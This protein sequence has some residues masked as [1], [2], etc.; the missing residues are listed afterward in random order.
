MINNYTQH[1]INKDDTVTTALIK[2]NELASDAILFLVDDDLKLYGSLTDGDLRRG[3][4]EGKTLQARLQAFTQENPKKILYDNY[5]IDEIIKY[6]NN[7]F[8]ILPIV[9]NND[10]IIDVINFNK[11]ISYLPLTAFI[12]AGGKGHR[13]RPLT[14]N[15]PKPMLKVGE[16]PILEHNIDSLIKYGIKNINISIKYLGHQIE[17]YFGNGSAKGINISYTNEDL[18]LGTIGSITNC[19]SFI[20]D[21]DIL[22]INSDLLTTINYEKM[23]LFFKDNEA[24]LVVGGVP[25]KVNVPYG[26]LESDNNNNIVSLTEKPTYTYFSN[27]GI[28][29]FKKKFIDLIPSNTHYNATDLIDKLLSLNLK[30]MK[31]EMTEYWLDIGKKDDFD[32]AQIDIKNLEY[33]K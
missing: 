16:K 4:I 23:Y 1:L 21:E 28:Y 19:E 32:K 33:F 24:D 20:N 14:L 22:L 30:V 26:V 5:L 10:V 18:P 3:L 17:E 9:N 6:R 31:Y 27:A 7:G 12:V 11:L 15:T 29:I 8:K 2:L 13:L 25:Y